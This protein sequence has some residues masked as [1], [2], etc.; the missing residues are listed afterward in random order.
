M[1][2]MKRDITHIRGL[3]Y[4]ITFIIYLKISYDL[5]VSYTMEPI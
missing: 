2:Q 4:D 3:L 1:E 5:Y